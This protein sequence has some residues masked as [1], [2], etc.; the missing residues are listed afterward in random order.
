MNWKAF[1]IFVFLLFGVLLGC[2]SF[3]EIVD[4]DYNWFTVAMA[5]IAILCLSA[6]MGL[7]IGSIPK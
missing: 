7:S 5:V 2:A 3:P 1:L 4:S 6:A